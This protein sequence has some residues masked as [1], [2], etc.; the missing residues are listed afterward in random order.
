[1]YGARR[2]MQTFSPSTQKWEWLIKKDARH[3]YTGYFMC[4]AP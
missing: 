4:L 3:F 1:M 2:P